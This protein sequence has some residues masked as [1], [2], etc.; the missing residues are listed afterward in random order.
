MCMCACVRSEALAA[1]ATVAPR[2]KRYLGVRSDSEVCKISRSPLVRCGCEP[3]SLVLC[4]CVH[5][6]MVLISVRQRW[7]VSITHH[8]CSSSKSLK[9]QCFQG[10]PG[11][12]L[13]Q[14]PGTLFQK[15][16]IVVPKGLIWIILKAEVGC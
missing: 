1:L 16:H 7:W 11:L 6:Y 13:E 15:A 4:A 5:V 8:L 3:A 14:L 12:F 2:T 9:S 10:F